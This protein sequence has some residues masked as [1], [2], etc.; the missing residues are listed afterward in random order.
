MLYIKPIVQWAV[1]HFSM[2]A[3]VSVTEI[4]FLAFMQ[5]YLYSYMI[6]CQIQIRYTHST[7][8]SSEY[9]YTN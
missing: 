2:D 6:L 3:D 4:Y 7:V 9:M 8:H 1:W 5:E